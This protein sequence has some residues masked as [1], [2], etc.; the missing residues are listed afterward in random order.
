MGELPEPSQQLIVVDLEKFGIGSKETLDQFAGSFK[1]DQIFLSTKFANK[2]EG[3]GKDVK[4]SVNSS[5][6]YVK[7]ACERV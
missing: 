3:E 6:E 1:R 4:I 5:P 2:R 7:Q